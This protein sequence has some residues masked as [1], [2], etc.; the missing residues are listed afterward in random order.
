MIADIMH[1][2]SQFSYDY[3]MYKITFKQ[4]LLWHM[5][6]LRVKHGIEVNLN[7]NYNVKEELD[8]INNKFLWNDERK[9][10]E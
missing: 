2:F 6:A 5:Q 4:F 7:D 1:A 9:R 8:E 3:L 10:W